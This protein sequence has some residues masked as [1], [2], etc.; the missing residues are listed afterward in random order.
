MHVVCRPKV[1]TRHDHKKSYY[2]ALRRAW[3]VFDEAILEKVKAALRADGLS[4]EL[5][6]AK[7]YFDFPF[8]RVRVPRGVPPP[9]VHYRR[10]RAVFEF[11]GNRRDAKTGV[12]LFNKEAWLKAKNVLDEILAGNCVDP[13]DMP[14]YLP[15]IDTDGELLRD[16]YGLQLY[17]C[18]RGTNL[19]ECA[20]KQM[21]A[22][23]GSW[24]CGVE[25]SDC[26]LREWRHRYNHSLAER[27][28]PGFPI[29]GHVDTWLVNTLQHLVEENHGLRLYDGWVN[30][31][32]FID[33]NEKF[34]TVP[35]H[36]EQLGEAVKAICLDPSPKLT[37]DRL[38]IAEA[39]E[40]PL[41]LLPLCH[42]EASAKFAQVVRNYLPNPDF[43]KMAVDWCK[44]VNGDTIM[45]ALPAH[46][47]L[48]FT[49][50]QRNERVRDAVR[51]AKAGI[52]VLNALN[53]ATT[54]G[55]AGGCVVA[56]RNYTVVVRVSDMHSS[57]LI[58]RCVCVIDLRAPLFLHTRP[59]SILV[60]ERDALSASPA[61]ASA[62]RIVGGHNVG[63]ARPVSATEKRRRGERGKDTVQRRRRH[64]FVCKSPKCPG[65]TKRAACWR[66]QGKGVKGAQ[67]RPRRRRP[68]TRTF[69]ERLRLRVLPQRLS[70]THLQKLADAGFKWG[71]DFSP[72]ASVAQHGLT[73]H[74]RIVN[75]WPGCSFDAELHSWMV[76]LGFSTKFVA[77]FVSFVAYYI[78]C[79]IPLGSH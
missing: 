58:M 8:F 3:F 27:R 4:E 44:Y 25:M 13:P 48:H 5:I 47:R 43:H 39:M 7:M 22:T 28:R 55:T 54:T 42:P 18:L 62:E 77:N 10:V 61:I 17:D 64:C 34:G 50:W 29:L 57:M 24:V 49:K 26:L 65:I 79:L 32:D 40:L 41:P 72:P 60:G 30:T 51:A 33:T 31:S 6:E 35:L 73:L 21:L 45:P 66:M 46:L 14:M 56:P 78:V 19:T 52:D 11:F 23:F 63:G 69:N 70:A 76:K 16:S 15:R 53:A 36:S 38:Y 37:G 59:A 67:K 2:V 20:H 9:D 12:P 71:G 74:A 68:A 1:P 75:F